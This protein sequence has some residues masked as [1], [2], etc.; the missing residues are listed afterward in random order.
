VHHTRSFSRVKQSQ[1]QSC[2]LDRLDHLTVVTVYMPITGTDDIYIHH[3]STEFLERHS[4][5]PVSMWFRKAISDEHLEPLDH[6]PGSFVPVGDWYNLTGRE[7]CCVAM[8]NFMRL[9]FATSTHAGG[10]A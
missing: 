3:I 2:D 4:G 8:S 1:T 5:E 9:V 10:T 6:L 7:Q